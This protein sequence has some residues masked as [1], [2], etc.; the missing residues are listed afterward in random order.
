MLRSLL[1][2]LVAALFAV[3]CQAPTVHAFTVDT[4]FQELESG[5]WRLTRKINYVDVFDIVKIKTNKP[6]GFARWDPLQR[7]FTMFDNAGKYY[8]FLQSTIETVP[9]A[10][11]YREQLYYGQGN[12][13]KGVFIRAL[14]GWP[15]T[16][17]APYSELGGD[18]MYFPYGSIRP[19]F[20]RTRI[21]TL[22]SVVEDA[23]EVER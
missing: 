1:L 7:R 10:D 9:T 18:F 14:G 4:Q 22:P 23:L 3:S 13:Y 12:R 2:I 6:V 5:Q 15:Q 21:H 8:G 11:F 20:P 16:E 17:E 19:T